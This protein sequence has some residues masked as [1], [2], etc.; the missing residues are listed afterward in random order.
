MQNKKTNIVL[1]GMAGAGKSSV[2]AALAKALSLPFVD[3]DTLI[4]KNQKAP[5]QKVL[6]TLGVTNFRKLEEKVILRM[7]PQKHV[8]A[9]GGSAIYSDTGMAH[10]KYSSILILLDVPLSV[11]LHRIGNF[12]SRGLV[13]AD[14]QSFEQL[15]TE[16]QP[17]YQKHADVIVSCENKSIEL[18]CQSIMEQIADTFYHL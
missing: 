6:D 8:I 3:V 14:G 2:G 17:L 5:L 11:L 13:K 9:T 12:N 4:E 1:I 18:I 16:R 15:F 7:R 10:L